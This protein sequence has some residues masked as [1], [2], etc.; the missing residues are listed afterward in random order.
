VFN[1]FPCACGNRVSAFSH[2][3]IGV[4]RRDRTFA[5]PLNLTI[6]LF[7][8]LFH[9]CAVVALF[10]FSWKGLALALFLWWV[11]ESLAACGGS[12]DT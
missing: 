2:L 10:V 4:L 12:L 7:L 11:A 1:F 3:G 6:T 5:Q 9:V 8:G